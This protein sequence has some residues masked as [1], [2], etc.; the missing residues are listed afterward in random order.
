MSSLQ[1]VLRRFANLAEKQGNTSYRIAINRPA[2]RPDV[3]AK[4]LGP[5]PAQTDP[6][7]VDFSQ[8]T[9]CFSV[10]L[11]ARQPDTNLMTVRDVL[12]ALPPPPLRK[13]AQSKWLSGLVSNPLSIAIELCEIDDDLAADLVETEV[14]MSQ[15]GSDALRFARLP[16]DA[17]S[18]AADTAWL[19]S[20]KS[21]AP[22]IP[23]PS[24]DHTEAVRAFGAALADV[25]QEFEPRS[26]NVLAFHQSKLKI[27]VDL[28]KLLAHV[29]HL[30]EMWL[31]DGPAGGGDVHDIR[32]AISS[33]ADLLRP[34]MFRRAAFLH[35]MTST[36]IP[37]ALRD[38]VVELRFAQVLANAPPENWIMPVQV[39][40]LL[41]FSTS[42]ETPTKI[43]DRLIAMYVRPT[44]DPRP[45]WSSKSDPVVLF[46]DFVERAAILE[47][48]DDLPRATAEKKA[49]REVAARQ[50][51]PP[52][53]LI[54]AWTL[55]PEVS[56]F[57][58]T[59]TFR[60]SPEGR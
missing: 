18:G 53:N 19:L 2:A 23:N 55:V 31:R 3:P 28:V 12:A 4:A 16:C 32:G 11:F 34:S 5:K 43:M 6:F 20:L 24:T 57:L 10:L 56:D 26:A 27:G 22:S 36:P 46:N 52:G 30:E 7:M 14:Q 42:A 41:P 25:M 39:E 47:Y 59:L 45:A 9:Q 38:A 44:S 35:V 60:T 54:R 13:E 17:E 49:L 48:D 29:Q 50:A 33:A 8:S 37:T 21:D 51:V 40:A 58:S 15:V 1:S